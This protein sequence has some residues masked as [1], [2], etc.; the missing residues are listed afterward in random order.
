MHNTT[1]STNTDLKSPCQGICFCFR[2]FELKE[3]DKK[4]IELPSKEGVNLL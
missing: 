2:I 4:A 1:I 3:K